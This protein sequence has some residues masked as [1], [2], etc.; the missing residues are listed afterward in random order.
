MTNAKSIQV[1]APTRSGLMGLVLR[2]LAPA[3]FYLLFYLYLAFEVD[4]RLVYNGGGLIDNFPTFYVDW[5]FLK[6][7][8][9]CPAGAVEYV[10]AFLAQLFY[11]SWAGAAVVTCQAWLIG[12]GTDDY[13]RRIGAS[14]LRVVRFV[15]PLVLAAV[16]SQYVF[17]FTTT[18][19]FAV[20]LLA[21]CLFLRFAPRRA[22]VR[23]LCFLAL[24]IVL[25]AGI[26]AAYLLFAVLCGGAAI[27]KD[28]RYREGL[29]YAASAAVV[30]GVVGVMIWGLS[31]VEAYALMLPI[32]LG[33]RL[34]EPP[35]LMLSAVAALYL[36]LPATMA[37]AGLWRF[38]LGRRTFLAKAASSA[39]G[40][41]SR[42]ASAP[43]NGARAGVL[44]WGIE[45]GLLAAATTIVLGL[46]HDPMLK[47]LFEVDFYSRQG[48][49]SKVLG[50]AGRC[51][52]H[53]L[54]CHAVDRALYH[55]GRLGDDMFG[56]YQDPKSLLLTGKEA[57]WQKVDTCME[58]GLINEA[59]NALTIS[60]E[61]YG[62]KPLL[63]E[64]LAKIHV[65][66]GDVET[67]SVYLRALSKVPF[68]GRWA[69]EELS[70]LRGDPNAAGDEEIRCLRAARLQKDFVRQTDFIT[71]LLVENPRN[72]M[73]YEYGMA[74]L[75]LNKNLAGFVRLFNAYHNGVESRIP[76]HYEEAI[77]LARSLNAGAVEL[78][79]RSVSQESR[80]RF[81]SFMKAVQ[82][83]GRDTAAARKALRNG[84]GD[85]YYYYFC[86]GG[87]GGQ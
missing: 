39:A 52:P 87:S 58:L 61:M 11:Y 42:K 80:D 86:L 25:Y 16:Y 38:T 56:Y 34:V 18:L 14:R 73:A 19:A 71:Q 77:L 15:G 28:R 59:E 47:A 65:V 82:P 7:Q 5:A 83:F 13:L 26:G 68:W 50:T 29:G 37:A 4:L 69:R 51:P 84:F 53:Y 32:Y 1:N 60:M 17:H 72:R 31:A 85:S 30:P 24:S 2:G 48:M 66:K 63:L 78:G 79:T 41:G 22:A 21:A 45:T 62:E 6:G 81:A 8:L 3:A 46:Y 49:W 36:F 10:A 33:T 43:Q 57:L 75:L 64:R 44:R 20:A 40:K 70:R 55:T 9:A 74:W 67:A 23:I 54:I 35:Q 12:W 76:R 27:V